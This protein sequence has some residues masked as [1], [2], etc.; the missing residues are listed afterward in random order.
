MQLPVAYFAVVCRITLNL[1]WNLGLFDRLTVRWTVFSCEVRSGF[2]TRTKC[3]KGGFIPS[4]GPFRS[5][6]Y[7]ACSDFFQWLWCSSAAIL[8]FPKNHVRSKSIFNCLLS[9]PT[10]FKFKFAS[11]FCGG[12]FFVAWR[13][14][15]AELNSS[16]SSALFFVFAVIP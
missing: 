16:L 8:T 12:I 5:K 3:A 15:D 11:R 2:T 4:S 9:L 1:A 14:R 7:I 10:F 13:Q 6:H